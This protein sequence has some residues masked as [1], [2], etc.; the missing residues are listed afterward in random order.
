LK[1]YFG[2][3]I[4]KL[5][6]GFMRLPTYPGM[7]E[8]EIDIEQVKEMVD[9]YMERGFTYYDTAYRY[10]GGKSE[11]AIRLAVTERYDRD[12]FQVTTKLPVSGNTT[13]D[14]MK[15]ITQTSLE[16][17]GLDFF[18]LYFI[19]G[20]GHGPIETLDKIKVWDYLKGV[21]ESG[22]T[23]NIG[24]SYHGNADTLNRILD[25]HGKDIDIVQLQMNYI[26]WDDEHV[27]S[28]KCYEACVSHGTGVIVMEPVRGGTLSNFTPEIADIFKRANPEM[29]LASWALRYVMGLEGVVTVLSGMSE[30]GHVDDNTRTADSFVPLNDTELGV[31]AQVMDELKKIPT[32][33]CTE[34]RYCVEGC[35]QKIGIPRV[36]DLLNEYTLYQNLPGS[37]RLYGFITGGFGP[38]GGVPAKASDC[39][40]CGACEKECPQ[41]IKII[42]AMKDAVRLFE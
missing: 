11:E 6:F 19:H 1:N 9:L 5:G 13:L 2:K 18:D 21:K 12:K 14:E 29:S 42:D 39:I 23:K 22:K 33:P 15:T 20:I 16:R 28:R 8:S 38:F 34:C 10:H 27:Q 32:I 30:L 40:E 3:P 24:F 4:K 17:A 25:I 37:R 26:D 31:L 36:L 7:P 41:S 35:P